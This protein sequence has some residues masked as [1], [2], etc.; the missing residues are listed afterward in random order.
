MAENNQQE[1]KKEEQTSTGSSPE[2]KETESFT[3]STKE[4]VDKAK[5]L[6]AEQDKKVKRGESAK[7]EEEESTETLLKQEESKEEDV[8]NKEDEA[9]K[10]IEGLQ[11]EEE[12][13]RSAIVDLR[14]ERRLAKQ[15]PDEDYLEVEE[16]LTEEQKFNA[17]LDKREAKTEFYKAHPEIYESEGGLT[18]RQT[19]EDYITLKFNTSNLS[20]EA[21]RELREMVHQK[22]FG[23]YETDSAVRKAKSDARKEH[24]INEMAATGSDKG[25]T[26][27]S[28]KS[29][30]KKK[31]ILPAKRMVEEIL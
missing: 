27:L 31:R 16:N 17:L 11:K 22:F 10:R 2:N 1:E 7:E 4:A 21:M 8:K 9:Q 24:L 23:A 25:K 19:I 18:R 20:S 28:P 12:R 13:L 15:S 3:G 26:L 14:K 6:K 30:Q 5:L 29:P